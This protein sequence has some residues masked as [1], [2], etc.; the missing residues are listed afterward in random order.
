MIYGII[1]TSLTFLLLILS[2]V[3]YYLFHLRKEENILKI[4]RYSFYASCILILVQSIMLMYGIL[5]H[6]FEW[7]YVFSYS[8]RDLP[9]NYLIATF[10]AGQEGTFLLW[11]IYGSL[12]GLFIIKRRKED[13]PLVMSFMA[14]IIAFLMLIL[15]KQNPFSYIWDVNPNGF[16]AGVVPPD[17]RGLNPLLQNPWMVIHPPILFSG[18]SS[19]MILFSFAMAALIRK[20]HDDWIKTVFPFALF[21]GLTLGIGIILGGYWAYTTLGWGG[22][23][24]WD[25]V[26]N[27]S[28]IPWLITLA[29]IHGIVIQRRH[30]GMKRVNIFLGLLSFIMVLYGSF[31]TR[32]GIL[33]DFSVHSFGE[34]PLVTYLMGFLFLFTGIGIITYAYRVKGVKGNYLD[35]GFFTRELFMSFGMIFILLLAAFTFVGTSWPL[36]SG[37]FFDKAES[38]NLEAYNQFSGPIAI[39]MG[40][41]IALAPVLSWKRDN[42]AKLKSVGIHFIIT[43]VLTVLAYIAGIRDLIPLLVTM[44]AIFVL[45]VNGQIVYQMVRQKTYAFGGYLAHVGIGLMLVGII[46][47]SVYDVAERVTLPKDEHKEVLG[48]LVQYRGKESAADGKD[49]VLLTVNKDRETFARFY[50]SDYSQAYMVSP[51]IVYT[52]LEDLYISPIQILSADDAP[53]V[54]KIEIRKYGETK[55]DNY[56]FRFIKYEMKSGEHQSAGEHM[57]IWARLEVLDNYGKSLGEI[58]PGIRIKGQKQENLPATIPG[59]QRNV[60]IDGV[61]V[62]QEILRLAVDKTVI[63]TGEPAKEMLAA[64]VSRKPLINILWLG[65][66]VLGAGFITAIY[67]RTQKQKL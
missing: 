52:F 13:E 54:D 40:F 23:W 62:E 11:S 32:S 63:K 57:V 44:A 5:N 16:A 9:L 31:L 48:Y 67:N 39:F 33:S 10:W 60:N 46:T 59:T 4:A 66:I 8:S 64:E 17:G 53:G 35:T 27:S 2:I 28:F 12:Y 24:A 38:V 49:K 7:S 47:S 51:S 1:A 6:H 21:V 41:L 30:G 18:Y 45:M 3:G 42:I 14:L 65:T 58:K 56:T 61:S 34:T 25:P 55:F 26:E 29:L 19:T 37:I 50:W 36:I 43:V 15:I 20:K 22:Y